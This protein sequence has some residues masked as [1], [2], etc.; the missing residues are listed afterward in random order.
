MP[1]GRLVI[2]YDSRTGNAPDVGSFELG[3]FLKLLENLTKK[4][5][6][7]PSHRGTSLL[8]RISLLPQYGQNFISGI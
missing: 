1:S 2:F 7:H 5:D 4:T 3:G 6:L 8:N